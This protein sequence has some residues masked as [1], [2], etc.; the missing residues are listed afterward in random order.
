M[1]DAL[2][3]E[4]VL[5][6]IDEGVISCEADLVRLYTWLVASTQRQRPARR[7]QSTRAPYSLSRDSS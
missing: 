1:R 7:R 5:A 4:L 3:L 2:L 6:A